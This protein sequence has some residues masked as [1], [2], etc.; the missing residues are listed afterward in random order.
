MSA[1]IG[2]SSSVVVREET[3][4]VAKFMAVGLPVAVRVGLAKSSR[5]GAAGICKGLTKCIASSTSSNV[6]VPEACMSGHN[7]PTRDLRLIALG[8]EEE[9]GRE[10]PKH[11]IVS[12]EIV[13]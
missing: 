12:N 9:A 1:R 5:P 6:S 10:M 3:A 8:I 11:E 13:K 4:R 7:G 2:D